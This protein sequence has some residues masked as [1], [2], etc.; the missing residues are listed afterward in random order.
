MFLPFFTIVFPMF[1]IVYHVSYSVFTRVYR[2]LP[3]LHHL[4][5]CTSRFMAAKSLEG[6][7]V[8]VALGHAKDAGQAFLSVGTPGAEV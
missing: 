4:E 3:L 5:I 6:D 8:D 2:C 1:T 7:A